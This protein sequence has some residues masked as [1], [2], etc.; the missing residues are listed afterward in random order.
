MILYFD[1]F[2]PVPYQSIIKST[3]AGHQ[4]LEV[5]PLL[6]PRKVEEAIVGQRNQST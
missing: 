5:D 3:T 6:Q 2:K 4:I 1:W